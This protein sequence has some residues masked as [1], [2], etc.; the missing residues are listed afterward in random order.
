MTRRPLTPHEIVVILRDLD[1]GPERT[2]LEGWYWALITEE[3]GTRKA[4]SWRK[5]YEWLRAHRD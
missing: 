4:D 2:R 5:E 3:C 1:D